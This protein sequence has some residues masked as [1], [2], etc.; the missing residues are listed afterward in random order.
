[1]NMDP[2]IVL[3]TYQG[4]VRYHG[5]VVVTVGDETLSQA[6]V[7]ALDADPDLPTPQPWD[8]LLFPDAA[9]GSQWATLTTERFPARSINPFNG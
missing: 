1:M 3:L 8:R 2:N 4:V 9:P 7:R 6:V 5:R